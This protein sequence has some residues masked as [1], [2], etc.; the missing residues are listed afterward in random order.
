M[1]RKERVNLFKILKL[2]P[3]GIFILS[4]SH[5]SKPKLKDIE[6]PMLLMNS[7]DDPILQ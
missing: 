6:I 7:K 4:P 3:N 2:I 1:V 5:S